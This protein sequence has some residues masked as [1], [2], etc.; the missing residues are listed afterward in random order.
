MDVEYNLFLEEQKH[1]HAR[2]KQKVA[3]LEA[4]LENLKVN[5]SANRESFKSS[6]A[7]VSRI[8]KDLNDASMSEYVKNTDSV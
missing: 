6:F 1:A 2:T 3:F 5:T 7:E 8:S 4:S